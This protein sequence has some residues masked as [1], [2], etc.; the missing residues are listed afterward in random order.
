[1]F[2]AKAGRVLRRKAGSLVG[3]LFS[4]DET[5][6]AM[7]LRPYELHLELTN[8]CNAN[9]VFCPYQ[10]QERE[11]RFMPDA[12]FRKAVDDFVACGGG[13]VG[14][15][16][17]VGDALIH[18]DFVS[19]VRHLRSLPAIDRIW[20]TTNAILLDKH[21]IGEV[22]GS[23][24]TSI[25]ISTSGFDEPSYRRIY[26]SSAYERFRR[27]VLELVERNRALPAPLTVTIGLRTD[28]PLDEVMRD[29][30]FQPILAHAPDVDFTWSFTSA[31]GRIT[32]EALPAGMQLRVVSA[33]KETCVQLY[34]G[35]IVLPD[36]TVMACSCVAAM[37]AVTDL[38]VGNVL[39]ESLLDLWRSERT[40]RLR[41]SF[42]AGGLNRTC[43]G[44][45]MYRGLELYRTAE[46]RERA[47]INRAR[48]RGEIVRREKPKG[49]FSGG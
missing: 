41:A 38:G 27:N 44:C 12:V 7:A 45:D 6:E 32:R 36:G 37:D 14:L 18:P 29:P 40:A 46:G 25:T 39:Q 3:R 10:F 1:M 8:L 19:R 13:S 23:G 24:L 43:A 16:P 11:V 33:R 4:L 28:R 48:D 34:N 21:G 49:A 35:P 47:R 22:L 26:R 20:V 9:C 30:D 31:G 17:I 5:L 2:L 15:T 42:G